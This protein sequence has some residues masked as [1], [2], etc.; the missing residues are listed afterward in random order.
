[1]LL[2]RSPAALSAEV[3]HVAMASAR[4]ALP[5]AYG[6]IKAKSFRSVVSSVGVF[7]ETVDSGMIEHGSEAAT[8]IAVGSA[9]PV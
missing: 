2:R 6:R 8:L 1:M 4:L 7:A 3:S 9:H 5:L